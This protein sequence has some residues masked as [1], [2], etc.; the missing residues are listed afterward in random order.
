MRTYVE[1]HNGMDMLVLRQSISPLFAPT[2]P[3]TITGFR[4]IY[5]HNRC[6]NKVYLSVDGNKVIGQCV[7]KV[8]EVEKG[9]DLLHVYK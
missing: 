9:Q 2:K 1:L 7:L 4:I 3:S 6:I 5:I 8:V